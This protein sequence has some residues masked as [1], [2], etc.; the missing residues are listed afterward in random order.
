MS[1][2]T[3]AKRPRDVRLDVFRG[4]GLM[5]IFISHVWHNPWAELI[6][7]RFGF[8]DATEIFVFCSGM[9]SALAF[10]SI[11]VKRGL[12]MGAARIA[13]RCWQVYWAHIGTLLVA[14]VCMIAVDTFWQTGGANVAGLE[15]NS[16]FDGRGPSAWLG[17][18]TLTY[19]PHF[20]DILP[21]YLIILAMIPIV[22]ML[23]AQRRAFAFAFVAAVWI[24]AFFG[25]ASLP[26][27]PWG[28]RPWFFNPFS[29]QLVFFTGFA[30]MSGWLPA[31]PIRR[32][33]VWIAA[34]VLL[35]SLPLSW[36]VLWERFE[37]LGSARDALDPLTDKTRF[38]LLRYVHFLSVAYLAYAAAGEGGRRLRAAGFEIFRRVG[39]QSL[40]VFM[41]G[42]VL[43]FLASVILNEWGRDPL[44]VAAVNSA[45]IGCLIVLAYVVAWF[46]SQPWRQQ[47]VA[48]PA[49]SADTAAKD[50]AGGAPPTHHLQPAE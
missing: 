6:P 22:M 39:Q 1:E 21:M 24:V 11:F 29:W 14:L 34:A 35:A 19:V 32:T 48:A 4:L 43:S 10:G 30:F 37:V 9:A 12:L 47:P 46:K 26:A 15:L 17:L 16:L 8:S 41:S 50:A 27:E 33:L 18:L 23:A 20:F 45:G 44:T 2:P 25:Y 3:V 38:G 31:P 28:D 42:L 49:A 40:A 7:A 5:I 36:A 13:H